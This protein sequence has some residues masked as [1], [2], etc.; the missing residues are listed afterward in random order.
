MALQWADPF[1][2]YATAQLGA[3]WTLGVGSGAL[4]QSAT[5]R[6]G[7]SALQLNST[8]TP[9][10][11]V[12][13]AFG[14]EGVAAAPSTVIMGVA[15]QPNVL[16]NYGTNN[17]L[18]GLY[19]G[20]ISTQQISLL[21]TNGGAL[22]VR[23]G[24]SNSGTTLGTSASGVVING[25]FQ[26]IEW[27]VVFATTAV[28]S[29]TVQV[30]GVVVLT[31][32]NVQTAQSGNASASVY[33]LGNPTS[34]FAGAASGFYD[35]FYCFD[36]TGTTN[37]AM[38]GDWKVTVQT[39]SAAGRVTTWAQTGGTGGQPWTAVN[40]VPPDGDTSYVSSATPG[41]IEDFALSALATAT[42]IYAVLV[43][44]YARKDDAGTRTLGLG[45]GNNTTENFDAGQN[46]TAGY[47]YYGRP[48]DRN[49]ITTVAWQTADFTG[50]AAIQVA[51]E[52][53]A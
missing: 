36:G 42:T 23:R 41:Q 24:D 22:I 43:L 20:G 18:F 31:L 6:T 29:V 40:E 30:N 14:A 33:S 35:D 13:R 53:I 44:A 45:V 11:S 47:I 26:T 46:L 48:M 5:V 27:K 49:P 15:F 10:G 50:A 19:D 37:N 16:S 34:N 17:V 12:T 28:G 21:V 1:D 39:P 8:Q 9:Q 32:T 7:A 25:T 52:E 38:L 51:L 4:I 2:T 3:M